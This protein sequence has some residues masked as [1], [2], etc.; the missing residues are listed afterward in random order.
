MNSVNKV[1][2]VGNLGKDPDIRSTQTG[3]KIANLS[4][5]T[6]ESWKDKVSGEKKER[7]EWHNVVVFNEPLVKLCEN[8]LEKGSKVYIEG[9]LESRKWTDKSGVEKYTTEIVLRPYKGEITILSGK[10]KKAQAASYDD[11]MEIPFD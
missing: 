5:A 9:K 2:L 3:A 11:D 8:Y 4:I 7:T 6:S 10:D 1:T